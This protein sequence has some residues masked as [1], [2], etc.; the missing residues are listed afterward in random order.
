MKKVLLFGLL[1][2]ALAFA[3][4]KA[5]VKSKTKAVAVAPAPEKGDGY[6]I[7]GE[8]TG[9]A[10]GTK[11]ALL[12]GTTGQPEQQSGIYQ[13]KFSFKGKLDKPAF[14]I[15]L[16]D[17][18]PPYLTLFL[19]NSDVKVAGTKDAFDKAVVSGSA[20]N[21]D[22]YK[23]NNLLAPYQP[24][25]AENAPADENG[26]AAAKQ[27]LENFIQRNTASYIT[28]L[29]VIRYMQ[30]NDD[31]MKADQLFNSLSADVRSSDLGNYVTQQLSEQK[32]NAVGTVMADFSQPDTTGNP[33]ALSSLRG[34]YVLVDFWASW[35]RPC[36]ME[37]PNVVASYQKYKDKNFTVLGVS[38][39]KAKPAWIDAIKMDNLTWPHVSD[40]KGWGNEVA[41]QFK[42]TS[43][44]QN[45]LIGP[46]GK[47]IAKNLR[48]P[49]L[50][51][52]LEQL[53]K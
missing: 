4:K 13:N 30:L 41:A 21:S 29:A 26:K 34:K 22:F 16:V 10:D 46:D 24:Y 8:V 28:P 27:T 40:L 19:D 6:L 42:V 12:N 38:L 32:I 45:F 23:L 48:G 36:R 2:P 50:D 1:F 47:I 43:I 51:R 49:A 35:C 3:Q 14:K 9:F 44:P 52:K 37:N 31:I 33:V 53:L 25:F 17:N 11:I 7:N 18:K 15:I 20:S 5:P 39:D